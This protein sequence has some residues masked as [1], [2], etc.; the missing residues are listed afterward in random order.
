M[1]FETRKT[2]N[3]DSTFF[4]FK[5]P[6]TNRTL[7]THFLFYNTPNAWVHGYSS[8]TELGRYVLFHDYD[9]LDFQSI[10]QELKYL[11]KKF[12][13]S[14]YYIFE[15]DRK[16]S[17]HAVCLDTFSLSK[18]YEIQQETSSDQAFIHAI[19]NL[20]TREWILRLGSKG[21]RKP[22]NYKCVIR[23]NNN[24]FV[25]SSAHAGLLKKFGVSKNNFFGNKWDGC[26]NIALVKYDTAN[27]VGSKELN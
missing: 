27:R 13:L 4:S 18:A 22:S 12:K 14:N 21:E 16:N 24:V 10:V 23:S 26:K 25:K 8:R 2:E 7:R 17:F 9:N 6:Y 20:Q 3:Y 19:K 15:L 1:K 11:Q 5:V